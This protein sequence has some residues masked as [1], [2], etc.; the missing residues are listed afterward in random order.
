MSM[1]VKRWGSLGAILEAAD[2][3]HQ[4]SVPLGQTLLPSYMVGSPSL[5]FCSCGL[6]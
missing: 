1:N 3:A 2:H 6:V 5:P 4:R